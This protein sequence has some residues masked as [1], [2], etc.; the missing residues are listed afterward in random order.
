MKSVRMERMNQTIPS[1]AFSFC[2]FSG[3]P[4]KN[5]YRKRT[6]WIEEKCWPGRN[7]QL[8]F[9]SRHCVGAPCRNEIFIAVSSSSWIDKHLV[10]DNVDWVEKPETM[11]CIQLYL[12]IK[13]KVKIFNTVVRI[14]GTY[15]YP[16]SLL[17]GTDWDEKG[18]I[19]VVGCYICL[20]ARSISYEIYNLNASFWFGLCLK[21]TSNPLDQTWQMTPWWKEPSNASR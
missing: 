3:I 9:Q 21:V 19:M 1:Q 7:F 4:K 5:K 18:D 12:M 16:E 13:G 6:S 15:V 2:C 20:E 17:V 8:R 11:E 10:N 14:G